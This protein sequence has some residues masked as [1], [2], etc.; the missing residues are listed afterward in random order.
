MK[1][2]NKS[3]KTYSKRKRAKL[4]PHDRLKTK[5]KRYELIEPPDDIDLKKYDRNTIEED[6]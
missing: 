2:I 3:E 5:Y 1:N 4:V 6:W